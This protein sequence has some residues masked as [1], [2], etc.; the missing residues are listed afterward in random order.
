MINMFQ[1]I[2]SFALGRDPESQ[3][4]FAET[5]RRVRGAPNFADYGGASPARMLAPPHP[6]MMRAH[7]PA[8]PLTIRVVP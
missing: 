5:S 7:P 4:N 8:L 3:R 6:P 2:G 1:K